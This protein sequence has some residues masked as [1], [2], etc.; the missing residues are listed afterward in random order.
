[1]NNISHQ[2]D[3]VE[4]LGNVLFVCFG[5]SERLLLDKRCYLSPIGPGSVFLFCFVGTTCFL[6]SQS[7]SPFS[8]DCAFDCVQCDSF[9]CL[10]H[11]IIIASD[12]S[13]LFSWQRR[14]TVS[15]KH[16][17]C[18][19]PTSN[20]YVQYLRASKGLVSAC[21]CVC[22]CVCVWI[23]WWCVSNSMSVFGLSC[24]QLPPMP[25]LL[26][27]EVLAL[28][29]RQTLVWHHQQPGCTALSADSQ[30]NI[31]FGCLLN[32][33]PDFLAKVA[34][35]SWRPVSFQNQQAPFLAENPDWY[36]F[37]KHPLW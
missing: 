9:N 36:R 14:W 18:L 22:L 25:T 32:I 16:R 3:F 11:C 35:K 20:L 5:V 6:V 13:L 34:K 2:L 23:P 1:M 37:T 33:F 4:I 27:H 26:G 28:P 12:D 17:R 19:I 7:G 29:L 31:H 21:V 24:L 8:E 10:I 30:G 15:S